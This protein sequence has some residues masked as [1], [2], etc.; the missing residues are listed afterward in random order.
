MQIQAA[1]MRSAQEEQSKTLNQGSRGPAAARLSPTRIVLGAP[2]AAW[3]LSHAPGD[4]AAGAS[5]PEPG[6][7][8]ANAPSPRK[9]GEHPLERER[10]GCFN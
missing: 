4:Q 7:P 1:H 8:R 6:T 9:D 5:A 10:K 3:E 2:P